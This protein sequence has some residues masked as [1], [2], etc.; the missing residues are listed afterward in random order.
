VASLE[1][2]FV[3]SSRLLRRRTTTLF[4]ALFYF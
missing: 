1:E 2:P 4:I 3:A